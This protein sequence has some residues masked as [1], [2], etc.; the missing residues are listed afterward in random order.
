MTLQEQRNVALNAARGILRKMGY[1]IA[2][3]EVRDFHLVLDDLSKQDKTLIAIRWYCNASD[4][5]WTLFKRE[6]KKM[7][8][9]SKKNNLEE[10]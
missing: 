2:N 4:N 10:K 7:I 9:E 3:V 8:N 1:Q 6:A 5:Q